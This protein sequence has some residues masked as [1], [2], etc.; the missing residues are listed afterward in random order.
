MSHRP[1][2]F[3]VPGRLTRRTG[4]SI[5]DRL[6]VDGLRLRDSRV[7]VLELAGDFPAGDFPLVDA[8]AEAELAAAL[9]GLADEALVVVD[10]L[11]LAG[12]PDVARAHASRLTLLGL[13]HLLPSDEPMLGPE[14]RHRRARLERASLDACAGLIATSPYTARRIADLGLERRRIRTVIP[15]TDPALP[16]RGPGRGQPPQI[17]CVGAVTPGKGQEVLVRALAAV[18]TE[19]WSCVCAGSLTTSPAYAA[20]V[21]RSI[22]AAGLSDRI[23]LV[24]ECDAATV[25]ELY[26]TSSI[27]VLPSYFESYGMVLTEAMA[28]GLPIVSTTA[29]A[30]PDTVPADAGILVAPGDSAALAGALR[31]LIGDQAAGSEEART[32]RTRLADAARRRASAL[33]GW[34]RQV[35]AFSEALTAFGGERAHIG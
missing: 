24:G 17:L 9:A 35:A 30:I 16:A 13:V 15:G 21:E 10:F 1:V 25:D 23:M 6:M 32:R 11:V 18:A 31:S 19:P 2:H 26:A 28:R 4:G 34:D 8:R 7:T 12:L 27:F 29:G 20:A 3:I 33:P 5:Y 14:E 22:G